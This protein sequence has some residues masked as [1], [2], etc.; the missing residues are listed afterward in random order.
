MPNFSNLKVK[1]GIFWNT[2]RFFCLIPLFVSTTL[3]LFVRSMYQTMD[4]WDMRVLI[5]GSAGGTYSA[6]SE[7]SMYMSV[8]YGKFLKFFYSLYPQGFWYDIFTYLFAG[9]AIY[10]STLA[11]FKNF[12]T[13]ASFYKLISVVCLSFIFST[14]YVYPQFT[15]TAGLLA[16]SGVF[17]F[18]MLVSRYFQRKRY[19]IFCGIY[20]FLAL[21]FSS[22]I[23][24]ECCFVVSFFTGVVLLPFWPYKDWKN[25]FYKS[26]LIIFSLSAILLC[27][28]IGDRL[29]ARVPA[30]N[31]FMKSNAARVEITD[32][33]DMW[34]HLRAPWKNIENHADE[35]KDKGVTFSKGDYRLLLTTHVLGN[36]PVNNVENLTKVSKALKSKLNPQNDFS[37]S[38]KVEDY[39]DVLKYF[40]LIFTVLSLCFKST[41]SSSIFSLSVFA[42]TVLCLNNMFRAL[43]YRLWYN[44]A[45]ATLLS[46]F[47]S[48][49]L[50]H[51]NIKNIYR[52][53]CIAAFV[54]FSSFMIIYNQTYVIRYQY[55]TFKTLRR[56]FRFLDKDAL[57]LTTYAFQDYIDAPFSENIFFEK[58]INQIPL[59]PSNRLPQYDAVLAKFAVSDTHTWADICTKD[60]NVYLLHS[61]LAYDHP[62]IA[63]T[64]AVSYYMRE[65]YAKTVV[66]LK[67]EFSP[68]LYGLKC[69]SLSPKQFKELMEFREID[70]LSVS[71]SLK[72]ALRVEFARKHL[73]P[74]ATIEEVVDFIKNKN[75]LIP[76]DEST[77]P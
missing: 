24:F 74:N 8:I 65:K 68:H 13:I 6:P 52:K 37:L 60:K 23:R 14:A 39:R 18:Y 35:I 30:W 7:F 32:K 26:W 16:I 41:R 40:V 54:F 58:G 67:K 20:C 17:S 62:L 69:I 21:L 56:E 72:D 9:S 76:Q 29:T 50:K 25:I 75:V 22:L 1:C 34:N 43:P 63:V 10:V 61:D 51:P 31:D 59:S 11:L 49:I 55:D 48:I 2:R 42:V 53:I 38:F 66:F 70:D 33:T 44:F 73:K 47:I 12:D 19:N 5:E 46:L 71:A 28:V 36:A 27:R 45:V 15:I 64:R 57:Y 3:A 4:D 77:E